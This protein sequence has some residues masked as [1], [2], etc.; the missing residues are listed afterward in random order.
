MQNDFKLK[1]FYPHLDKL[2]DKN[3]LQKPIKEISVLIS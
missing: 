1:E 2:F 3:K